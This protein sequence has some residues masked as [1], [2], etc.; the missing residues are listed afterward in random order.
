MQCKNVIKAETQQGRSESWQRNQSNI[1]G[2]AMQHRAAE[3]LC[4]IL[5]SQVVQ[6]YQQ[7]SVLLLLLFGLCSFLLV[8]IAG[9]LNI[10]AYVSTNTFT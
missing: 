10:D 2:Y 1:R 7:L 3:F 6:L 9:T 5:H 4:S 8:A